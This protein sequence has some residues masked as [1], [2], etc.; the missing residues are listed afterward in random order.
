MAEYRRSSRFVERILSVQETCR[1][2]GRGL[3]GYL[4][5]CCQAR[6]EGQDA[7]S[8]LPQ[9]SSRFEVA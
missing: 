7:P 3:L 5:E 4:V 2:Q 6:L 8:L 1:Q 9:D